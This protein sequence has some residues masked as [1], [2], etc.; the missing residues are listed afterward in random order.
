MTISKFH[1]HML[2]DAFQIYVLLR[3]SIP[4]I[5]CYNTNKGPH[6]VYLS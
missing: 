3:S 1:L 6:Q 5:A 2:M 4:Q